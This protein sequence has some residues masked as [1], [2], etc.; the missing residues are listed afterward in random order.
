MSRNSCLAVLVGEEIFEVLFES[1]NLSESTLR[2]CFAD[3]AGSGA[4][5]VGASF[6]VFPSTG[7]FTGTFSNVLV[8]V[9]SLDFVIVPDEEAFVGAFLKESYCHTNAQKKNSPH[10]VT[11][12]LEYVFVI[13]VEAFDK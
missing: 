8:E 13:V 4:I 1:S 5:K 3:D 10:Y 11:F 6:L 9:L 12:L 2:L 7:A